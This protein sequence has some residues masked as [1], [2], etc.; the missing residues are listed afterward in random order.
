MKHE[1][2]CEHKKSLLGMACPM[3]RIHHSSGNSV[4]VN[5]GIIF[6]CAIPKATLPV[7]C[8]HIVYLVSQ[9]NKKM[10]KVS[11]IME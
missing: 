6:T 1:N 11:C 9:I 4:A 7:V 8:Q 5:N 2:I 10:F 3:L